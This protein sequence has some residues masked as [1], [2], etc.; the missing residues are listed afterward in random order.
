MK[1]L[2]V[3]GGLGP[4]TTVSFIKRVIDMTDATSD[5]EHIPMVVEHC[6]YTPDRTAFILGNSEESPLPSIT[7]A[8]KDLE[9]SGATH[10]A[11]PCVTAHYFYD[12]LS[13]SVEIPVYNGIELCV[14]AFREKG[15]TKVGLMATEGTVKSGI[16]AAPLKNAGITCIE[17]NDRNQSYVTRLIYNNVKMGQP[18][19]KEIFEHVVKYFESAGAEAIL[20]GCTELSVI[21]DEWLP[22]GCFLDMMS[23]LAR[24]CVKDYGNLKEEYR[25][26]LIV[27]KR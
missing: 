22:K 17:P 9:R 12:E 8:C 2:G 4:M 25:E 26:I 18:V 3:V 21:A 19:E 27:N 1:K 20:L 5:Q 10:I 23:A 16:F 15:I 14:K 24:E 7:A 11:M 13:K 6:C